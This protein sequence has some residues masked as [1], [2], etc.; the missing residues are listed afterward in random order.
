MTQSHLHP[1]MYAGFMEGHII[2]KKTRHA[3]SILAIDQ[4]YYQHNAVVK[5]DGGAVGLTECPCC[6]EYVDVQRTINDFARRVDCA[7]CTPDM[8][9][10]EQ[11][12]GMQNICCH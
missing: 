11:R 6:P 12:P 8:S 2:V 5:D 1:H 4:T 7:L 3:F 10:Y 9:H